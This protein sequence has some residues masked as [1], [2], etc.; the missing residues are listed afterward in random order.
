MVYIN[1]FLK[2]ILVRHMSPPRKR[3]PEVIKLKVLASQSYECNYCFQPLVTTCDNIP[4]YDI[5]HT[6][7]YSVSRNNKIENLQALCLNCHRVK[8]VR[9]RRPRVKKE[10]KKPVSS[11]EMVDLSK[12]RFSKF[13]HNE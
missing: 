11:I 6:E 4:L 2:L 5:D 9:E 8:S 3:I 13:V 10:K 1:D 7:M 12:N